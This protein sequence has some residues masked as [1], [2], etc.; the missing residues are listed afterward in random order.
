MGGRKDG[1][2]RARFL[3]YAENIGIEK[4]K[5][6]SI[7]GEIARAVEARFKDF[8]TSALN[9]NKVNFALGALKERHQAF[10]HLGLNPN[11]PTLN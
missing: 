7:M 2:S 4:T 11:S 8:D 9:P 3:E 5:A 6:E 10:M 1:I